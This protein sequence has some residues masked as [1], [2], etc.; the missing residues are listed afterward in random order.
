VLFEHLE[1]YAKRFPDAIIREFDGRDHQFNNDLFE[2]ACDIRALH[3]FA[4]YEVK[5]RKGLGKFRRI[6]P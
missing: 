1:M 5:H 6:F 2:V 4:R 3:E